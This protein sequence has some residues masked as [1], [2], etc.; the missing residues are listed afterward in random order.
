MPCRTTRSARSGCRLSPSGAVAHWAIL[1]LC[2]WAWSRGRATG[3]FAEKLSAASACRAFWGWAGAG[4]IAAFACRALAVSHC[5]AT[6][7][8]CRFS[9]T[10][11]PCNNRSTLHCLALVVVTALGQ[12]FSDSCA[13]TC[14]HS[15]TCL[16]SGA[17]CKGQGGAGEPQKIKKPSVFSD[18]RLNPKK[19]NENNLSSCQK[20]YK[21]TPPL[22][23][24]A[25]KIRLKT[26]APPKRDRGNCHH[27]LLTRIAWPRV[28]LLVWLWLAPGETVSPFAS[29][30]S[31][32]CRQ[33]SR[34]RLAVRAMQTRV[35][36]RR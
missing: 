34:Q 25:T 3:R 20:W 1:P 14:W 33:S 12:G 22:S 17:D 18:Q 13:T 2:G 23:I 21:T 24:P 6:R 35:G 31:A 16:S 11:A 9:R 30:F 5:G 19:P 28:M 27:E 10:T 26:P 7:P 15:C 36:H 8:R 4:G 29:P 32:P